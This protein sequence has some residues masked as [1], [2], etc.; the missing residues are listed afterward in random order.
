MDTLFQIKY[1][2]TLVKMW[3]YSHGKNID[4]SEQEYIFSW[5]EILRVLATAT[6]N[7]PD[8]RMKDKKDAQQEGKNL[9]LEFLIDLL[10]KKCPDNIYSESILKME[11]RR[12]LAQK[13]NPQ[14]YELN[15]ILNNALHKLEEEKKIQRD[16]DSIG[17]NICGLT[18]FALIDIPCDEEVRQFAHYEMNKE[19]VSFYQTKIR[20]ND[21][22]RSCI[23][24]PLNAQALVLELL[25]AFGGWTKKSDL[26]HAMRNHI[27]DQLQ[28][29]QPD[30]NEGSEK[31][32]SLE[33]NSNEYD[34][35]FIYEYDYKAGLK[36]VSET[37]AR[38]WERVCKISDKVFCL[39]T[40]P[41]RCYDA[42]VTLSS[43]GP[44]STVGDQNDKISKILEV[45]LYE[46]E[47][48][49]DDRCQA[50]VN[51]IIRK[52]LQNLEGRC[53]EKGMNPHLSS[54]DGTTEE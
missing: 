18:L 1:P 15:K 4:F 43:V 29:V 54:V 12:Y 28:F 14:Q 33:N 26:L 21:P 22:E 30:Q 47:Y 52:I 41:K 24:Q 20:A 25:Q 42:K 38:I 49:K 7:L 34:K 11:C 48:D 2:D 23:I 36:K 8:I 39:Y 17:K 51:E 27:P 40:L 6:E 5:E 46:W 3:Q 44:T 50:S 9:A 32:N 31:N 19:N 53:T 16:K 37:S 10:Q 35:S 13:R 45:E